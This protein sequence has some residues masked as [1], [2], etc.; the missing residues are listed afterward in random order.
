MI[1]LIETAAKM[2]R[3]VV[4]PRL[5]GSSAGPGREAVLFLWASAPWEPEVILLAAAAARTARPGAA[6]GGTA[7]VEALMTTWAERGRDG[8]PRLPFDGIALMSEL[9]LEA[10]PRL[11]IA[12][13]AA[14]LAWEAGEATTA[15]Q[16]L[17][18]ARA[19][20]NEG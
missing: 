7:A 12:L 19:A 3:R 13:R 6:A 10:G 20:L 9:G 14:R 2:R 11:G 8:V 16:A 15:E 1:S 18:A 4:P 17:A 5:A